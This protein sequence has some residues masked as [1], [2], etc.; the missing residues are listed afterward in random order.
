VPE[1]I[2][3]LA[4]P[5]TRWPFG[6]VSTRLAF[7]CLI[8]ANESVRRIEYVQNGMGKSAVEEF[9]DSLDDVAQKKVLFVLALARDCGVLPSQYFKR[10]SGSDGIYEIRIQAAGQIYRILCFW[11]K[12]NCLVLTH[13]FKKKTQKTPKAEIDIADRWKK[14]YNISSSKS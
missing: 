12:G 13:G 14:M 9:I 8:C 1:F 3:S 6:G 4:T 2:S 10:L 5:A 7:D 11:G